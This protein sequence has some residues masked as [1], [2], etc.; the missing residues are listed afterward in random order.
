M[1]MISITRTID[2]LYTG[3]PFTDKKYILL[4]IRPHGFRLEAYFID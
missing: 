3:N 1:Y 2:L 4:L